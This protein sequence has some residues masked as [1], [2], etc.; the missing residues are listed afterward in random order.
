MLIRHNQVLG[1]VAMAGHPLPVTPIV[2][3]ELVPNWDFSDAA[4]WT[5]GEGWTISGGQAQNSGPL[6][7]SYLYHA[8]PFIPGKRYR[9]LWIASAVSVANASMHLS[10][11]GTSGN[12]V[13]GTDT[14]VPGTFVDYLTAGALTAFVSPRVAIGAIV[15]LDS[16]SVREVIE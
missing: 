12:L 15:T 9:V 8:V 11:L 5:L 10:D 2:G 6:A 4:G 1:R 13:A 14:A 16:V 3:P 7:I